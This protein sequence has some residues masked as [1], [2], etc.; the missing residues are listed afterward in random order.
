MKVLLLRLDECFAS[1]FV[2]HN[3]TLN[4]KE[5]LRYL[6]DGLGR[7]NQFYMILNDII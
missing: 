5:A 6:N 4:K 3:F 7:W 2:Y 1:E